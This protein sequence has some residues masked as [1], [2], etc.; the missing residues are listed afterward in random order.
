MNT[1][2]WASL[3]LKAQVIYSYTKKIEKKCAGGI[4][5]IKFTCVNQYTYLTSHETVAAT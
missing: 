2:I 5:A 4:T 1:E 3:K